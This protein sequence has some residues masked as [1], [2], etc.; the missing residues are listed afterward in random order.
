MQTQKFRTP[1]PSVLMLARGVNR[2]EGAVLG[3]GS[4]GQI[5]SES[6]Q[7][8]KGIFGAK[9]QYDLSTFYNHD[10]PHHDTNCQTPNNIA[11]PQNQRFQKGSTS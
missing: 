4:S 9:T 6:G 3:N 11:C 7:L 10:Y 8:A 1:A 2:T 5:C